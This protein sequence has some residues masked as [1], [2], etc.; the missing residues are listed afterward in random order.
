MRV[1]ARAKCGRGVSRL[2]HR[3]GYEAS[4]FGSP[5]IETEHLLL[6]LLREDKALAITVLVEHRYDRVALTRGYASGTMHVGRLAQRLERP[7][8]TRKVECSNHSL[9]TTSAHQNAGP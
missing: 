2:N 6:G 4:Q 8:Y 5:Y 1:Y 3:R 7:V 9:P